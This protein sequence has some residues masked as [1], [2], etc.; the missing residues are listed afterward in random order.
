MSRPYGT[1]VFREALGESGYSIAFYVGYVELQHGPL[2]RKVKTYKPPG[3]G[4]IKKPSEELLM[5]V[6]LPMLRDAAEDAAKRGGAL[7]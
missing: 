6:A 4:W 7:T 5:S 1:F 3:L 2:H